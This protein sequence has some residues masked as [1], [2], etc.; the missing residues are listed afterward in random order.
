MKN[1]HLRSNA[2][3]ILK[4]PLINIQQARRKPSIK[5]MLKHLKKTYKKLQEIEFFSMNNRSE[6]AEIILLWAARLVLLIAG[7]AIVFL[8]MTY[9]VHFFQDGSSIEEFFFMLFTLAGVAISSLI[10][11]ATI[12]AFINISYRSTEIHKLLKKNEDKE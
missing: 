7:I 3:L 9:V 11:Y 8:F 1:L 12:I 4:T 6:I 10:T 2:T 5:P